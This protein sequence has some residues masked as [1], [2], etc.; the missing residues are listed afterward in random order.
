M[1]FLATDG[2]QMGTS[3]IAEAASQ[4]LFDLKSRVRQLAS[5]NAETRASKALEDS[6]LFRFFAPAV[7]REHGVGNQ[8]KKELLAKIQAVC[9]QV[10][11]GTAWIYHLI[12]AT[13]ILKL[14]PVSQFPGDVI[15][16]GCWKGASTASLS[17][18]C[19]M[20]GRRLVVC[21]SFAGLPD[22]ETD[23]VR[24]YPHIGVYGY[25]KEG[26]Y[27]GKLE[28]VQANIKR[29]GD[30]SVCDFRVGFFGE[31]L[32]TLERGI[33]FAFLDVDLTVSMQDCIRHLWPL[34]AEGAL[35]YTDDSC[36]MEV[37]RVWFDEAW[38][39]GVLG[40]K[41]PGYVGSGCGLPVSP[42]FSSL[43]YAKKVTHIDKSYQRVSWLHYS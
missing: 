42:G 41:A 36:D 2:V 25:Y 31:S 40:T 22:Q 1:I 8:A 12:L 27:E 30:L 6:I 39:Q 10:P 34:M 15:E 11:T 28:E 38:W 16:C 9:S 19:S 37:V 24:N 20:V 17:L 21:D 7:G 32:A 18:V 26:M 43:G 33:A 4:L 35:I 3:G 14:P 13:E 5:L 29:F 23:L